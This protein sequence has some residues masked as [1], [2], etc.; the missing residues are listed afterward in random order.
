MIWIELRTQ[1]P[2][3]EYDS[4]N[5][6]LRDLGYRQLKALTATDYLFAPV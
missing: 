1:G 4:G 6:L 3:D 5:A 2:F